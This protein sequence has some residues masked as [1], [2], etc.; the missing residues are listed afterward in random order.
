MNVKQTIAICIG[1]CVCPLLANAQVTKSDI[2]VPADSLQ[3]TVRTSNFPK[4]KTLHY[5]DIPGAP[6]LSQPQRIDGS[7]YEIRT[8]EH[9][10]AYPTIYD[11][12]H[13]GRPDL[14]MGEFLTGQS[15]IKVYLNVGTKKK[16]RFTGEW[17]YAKDK[18]GDVISNYQW[19]CIGIHPQIV[20]VNGDGIM[21]I[22]SGQ[23]FPGAIT[24]WKGT[25]EGFEPGRE[26]PQLGYHKEKRYS[27]VGGDE[28]D[29]S[30]EAHLYW[31]YSSARLAD[32]NGDGLP[33]LFV[34][35]C[36]GY[37]CALNIG[38]KDNPKFGRREFL[39]Q[40]DGTILHTYRNPN[41]VIGPGK[42]F[43][44][45]EIC[46][47]TA[48]CYLDPVDWDG[49]GILDL[50]ITDELTRS[51]E[52]GV[53]F[54]RGVKTDDGIRFEAPVPLFTTGDGSKALPG[55]CPH[56]QIV[57]YNGDGVNDI[58]MGLSIPTIKGFE[59]AADLYD[60]YITDLHLESPG[61]DTG[62]S[63]KY[64][65]IDDINKQLNNDPHGKEFYVGTTG[66][67][68]YLTLRH[69]GYPL[70]FLGR[71]NPK[72]AVVRTVKAEPC[73]FTY[74][75]PYDIPKERLQY[76]H[77]ET[78]VKYNA[79]AFYNPE[80]GYRHVEVY[81]RTLK[82]YHLYTNSPAND[83]MI[84]VSIT[85]DWPN[86]ISADGALQTP[87]VIMAGHHEI[88]DGKSLRF[89]QQ[90]KVAPD[91]KPGKYTVKIHVGYQS[92]CSTMCLPPVEE[93]V[94]EEINVK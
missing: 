1:A 38:T 41:E 22:M 15:R 69:R 25:P 57:D 30:P 87:P 77:E 51:R 18:N 50:F 71:K 44:A 27:D 62:E 78:P 65:S 56:V 37:R 45:V 3:Q 43:N 4:I 73:E 91:I 75:A 21:D 42:F 35:G 13:D 29:W 14:L 20:D 10:L 83:G 6:L 59:G 76:L 53:Y 67:L 33:D 2:D 64:F 39:F 11:W 92:C 74:D 16:P 17:F 82:D 81:F 68:R 26:I 86:G 23:Y 93:T 60:K 66:D 88:Y 7:E 8:E 9:G 54:A 90:Y 55:C 28:P 52:H 79:R 24:W 61:K 34:A 5:A 58:I 84:P 89:V 85:F 80:L 36:G 46:S 48:H 31:N 47:G 40:T 63:I 49:D 19:C 32:F 70:V 94:E 72:R 12:N